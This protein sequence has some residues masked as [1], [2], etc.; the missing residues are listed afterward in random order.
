MFAMFFFLS[1]FVQ[2]VMGYSPLQTG[3]AFLPFSFGIVI[4]A[5]ISSKL[6][7]P[8]RPALARRHRHRDGGRRAVRVLPAEHRRQPGTPAQ[9]ISA[10]GDL[11]AT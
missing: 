5:T 1:L 8:G 7:T 6:V 11:G 3:V 2:N 9:V 4:A 10:G